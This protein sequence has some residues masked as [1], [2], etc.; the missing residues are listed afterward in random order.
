MSIR[1]TVCFGLALSAMCLT[2]G[3]QSSTY[4]PSQK[5]RTATPESQ[6]IDSEALAA[7]I[8]DDRV[9]WAV[10]H[11]AVQ[12]A[13]DLGVA[14]I[15]CPTQSGT[16]ARRVAAF[17]PAEIEPNITRTLNDTGWFIFLIDWAP[18][19]VWCWAIGTAIITDRTPRPTYPRWAAYLSYWV[20]LAF[21]PAGLI[22]FFKTG[23]FAY[24]GAL[25]LYLPAGAFFLWYAVITTLTI[26][27]IHREDAEAKPETRFVA[28][29]LR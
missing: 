27:S 8:D 11:A 28:V 21:F 17:R 5:W 22:I 19:A 13:E 1:R 6:G 25:A 10:A 26:V 18:V 29:E 16:N 23:P 2:L 24:N 15:V 7:A 14:A 4:W 20:G 12:A 3:G 9:A